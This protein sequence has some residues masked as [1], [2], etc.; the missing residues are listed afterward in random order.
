LSIEQYLQQSGRDRQQDMS[1]RSAY[2]DMSPGD[3]SRDYSDRKFLIMKRVL[4]AVIVVLIGL[5][6]VGIVYLLRSPLGD[7]T[8]DQPSAAELTDEAY[9]SVPDIDAVQLLEQ[10]TED[11]VSDLLTEE[12]RTAAALAGTEEPEPAAESSQPQEES[13][14]VDPSDSEQP[15]AAETAAEEPMEEPEEQTG[16]AGEQSARVTYSRYTVGEGETLADIASQFNLQP[17]TIIS[18]NE[19]TDVRRIQSGMTLNIPDRDGMLYTVSSGDSLSVI[20]YRHGMGVMGYVEL[21]EVN[22]LTSQVIYPGDKLF[23][24]GKLM[25][26]V[27]Y[28][29]TTNTLFSRPA[30]GVTEVR[31]GEMRE[32]FVTGEYY[33]SE[34]IVIKNRAGTPVAAAADGVVSAVNYSRTGFGT[35]IIIEHADGFSTLYSHLATA[36]V[37]QG[38]RVEQGNE[39]GTIGS[40][41]SIP[42]DPQLYFEIRRDGTPLDP[43]QYFPE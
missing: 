27:E 35:H 40:T 23:I 1:K 17:Q 36:A 29:L 16:E 11:A 7:G 2:D 15:G 41:G 6:A 33:S 38:S 4:T 18:V 26:E 34:G 22:G 3:V 13:A 25:E 20:A 14:P 19:I 9:P 21:A 5:T 24:P 42:V 28:Q 31:F 10:E 43:E 12:Q 32:D 39:I 37:S 30:V 8:E